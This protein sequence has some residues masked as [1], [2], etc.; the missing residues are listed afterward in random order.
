MGTVYNKN[1]GGKKIPNQRSY[2]IDSYSGNTTSCTL[3][4]HVT[5]NGKT[6]QTIAA[7]NYGTLIDDDYVKWFYNSNVQAWQ[8]LKKGTK[9]SAYGNSGYVAQSSSN[10]LL[11]SWGYS[12]SLG[13]SRRA[14]VFVGMEIVL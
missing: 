3:R 1:G 10:G 5:E 4:G 7:N 2:W 14:T 6:I 8:I 11:S 9:N 13:Q 12:S